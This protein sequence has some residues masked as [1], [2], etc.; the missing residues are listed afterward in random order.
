MGSPISDT[1]VYL[2]IHDAFDPPRTLSVET[3][4]IGQVAPN[5]KITFEFNGKIDAR[6]VGLFMVAESNIFNSDI[7]RG[8]TPPPATRT[9]LGAIS[10]VSIQDNQ[11]KKPLN[12][13]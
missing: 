1:K 7:V 13:K 3:V 12:F 2:A 11:G 8:C 6:A 10:D 5:D 9:M 4:E